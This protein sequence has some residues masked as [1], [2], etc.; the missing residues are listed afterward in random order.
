MDEIQKSMRLLDPMKDIRE[1]MRLLDPMKDF[2]EAM[3][4]YDPMKGVRESMKL[5]DPMKDFRESMK[6]LDPMKKLRESMKLSDPTKYFKDAIEA[7][8]LIGSLGQLH[9]HITSLK[10]TINTDSFGTIVKEI[11]SAKSAAGISEFDLEPSVNQDGT[12][13]FVD[14]SVNLVSLQIIGEE[15]ISNAV[16]SQSEN[17]VQAI[18]KLITEVK[19]QKDPLIQRVL[20]QL[21]YPIVLY[22]LF[23]FVNPYADFHVKN[24]LNKTEKKQISKQINTAVIRHVQYREV[25]NTFRYV[26]ADVLSVRQNKNRSSILIGYLYFGQ[27]VKILEK[28]KNWTKVRWVDDTEG[29]SIKGWV[30]TRYLKRFK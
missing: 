9:Q 13:S 14:D 12:L 11:E 25:L 19:S 5:L 24:Y 22:L 8:K 28:Q 21:I 16:Q 7:T 27:S 29:N 3:Q 30:F 26:T 6:F 20:I 15:I 4:L 23:A 18:E 1:S 2:R 17:I 10:D